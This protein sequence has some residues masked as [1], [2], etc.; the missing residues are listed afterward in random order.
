MTFFNS[1][2]ADFELG[3]VLIE[4]RCWYGSMFLAVWCIESFGGDPLLGTIFCCVLILRLG[5]HLPMLLVM[6][7]EGIDNII[8]HLLLLQSTVRVNVLGFVPRFRLI[9][10]VSILCS[11]LVGVEIRGGCPGFL[12]RELY[13]GL[14]AT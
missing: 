12:I 13:V 3:A 4:S 14:E 5:S 10:F 11:Y 7:F 1:L 8:N 9:V 6:N 2:V